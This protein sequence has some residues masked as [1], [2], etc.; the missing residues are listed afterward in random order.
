[1]MHIVLLW[2]KKWVTDALIHTHT[3]LLCISE[4]HIFVLLSVD[5]WVNHGEQTNKH[6]T[7]DPRHLIIGCQWHC[8]QPARHS[9]NNGLIVDS[10]HGT[11]W[12][13]ES[14][15]GPQRTFLN[16]YSPHGP[17][18]TNTAHNNVFV[19]SWQQHNN[20]TLSALGVGWV[21]GW[22]IFF[23]LK[24]PQERADSNDAHSFAVG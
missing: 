13:V 24:H 10:P 14:P 16:A 18:R 1:M 6:A 7:Q 21:G 2:D 12:N 8:W 22:S 4:K 9:M 17:Q 20:G 19:C 3:S 15:H 11:Q 23:F 5:H